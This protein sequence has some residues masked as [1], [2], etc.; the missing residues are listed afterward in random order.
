[1]AAMQVSEFYDTYADMRKKV[2]NAGPMVG[3]IAMG[4]AGVLVIIELIKGA[5]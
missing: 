3:K 5:F 2:I 4:I 1:M